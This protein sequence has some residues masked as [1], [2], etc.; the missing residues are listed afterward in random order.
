[1]D[2]LDHKVLIAGF[3]CRLSIPL[4]LHQIFF[5]LVPVKVIEGHFPLLKTAHLHISDITNTSRIL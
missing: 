2:L 4:D 5:D 1:M 3:L